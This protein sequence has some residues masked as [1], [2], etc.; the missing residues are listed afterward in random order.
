MYIPDERVRAR[1]R[2]GPSRAQYTLAGI[3]VARVADTCPP[4]GYAGEYQF[5]VKEPS[6]KQ[7]H[8]AGRNLAQFCAFAILKSSSQFMPDCLLALGQMPC[9]PLL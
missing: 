8:A 9:S 6:R 1:S 2:Q 5:A 7:R 4:L 3:P